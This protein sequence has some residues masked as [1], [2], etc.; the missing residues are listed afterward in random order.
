MTQF[1]PHSSL[2]DVHVVFDRSKLTTSQIKLVY[3]LVTPLAQ[4]SPYQFVHLSQEVVA[5]CAIVLRL[6]LL[7]V[8]K[9]AVLHS[10]D[11]CGVGAL[12]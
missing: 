3:D 9:V 8:E 5:F 10:H 12:L 11:S 4:L 1:L 2:H 7:E 6:P